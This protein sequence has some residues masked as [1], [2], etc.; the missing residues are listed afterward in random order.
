MYITK[1]RLSPN[2]PFIPFCP[3]TQELKHDYEDVSKLRL[4]I[5]VAL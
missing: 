2:P 4:V 5:V 1:I 3:S